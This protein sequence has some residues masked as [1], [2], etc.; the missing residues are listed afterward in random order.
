MAS[1]VP[2]NDQSTLVLLEAAIKLPLVPEVS[3]FTDDLKL[4][5]LLGCNAR[6]N[7]L[8]ELL[9]LLDGL[10]QSNPFV[11]E[12]ILLVKGLIIQILGRLAGRCR[13]L[14]SQ[15]SHLWGP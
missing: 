9:D 13:C 10:W 1:I 12:L 11:F 14:F 6:I 5:A 8:V 15:G 2:L 7:Y 4:G 3:F